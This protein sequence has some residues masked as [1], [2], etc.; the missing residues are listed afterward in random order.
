MQ[1][2]KNYSRKVRLT[3]N[4]SL[5]ITRV[6]DV[7]LKTTLGLNWTLKNAK[8]ILDLKRM[9]IFVGQLDDEGHYV[10]LVITVE[11]NKIESHSCARSK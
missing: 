9:L 3:N 2:F 7:V 11:G 4:K 10:G 8:Y 6:G 5:Y 1:I